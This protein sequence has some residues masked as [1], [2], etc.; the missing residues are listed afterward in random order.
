[1]TSIK[2]QYG[3]RLKK[4]SHDQPR[5]SASWIRNTA[6]CNPTNDPCFQTIHAAMPI[7]MY[8]KVQ[9]GAKTHEGGFQEGFRSV[10]YQVVTELLVQNPPSAPT[11]RHKATKNTRINML[12]VTARY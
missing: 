6:A 5:L 1:M 7:V 9:T 3:L 4:K 2:A 8:K 12:K 10:T 11:P